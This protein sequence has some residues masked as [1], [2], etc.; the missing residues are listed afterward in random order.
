MSFSAMHAFVSECQI[1][2]IDADTL[3]LVLVSFSNNK[4]GG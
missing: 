2:G 3:T 1:G 4:Y